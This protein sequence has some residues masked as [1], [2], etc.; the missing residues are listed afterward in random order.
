MLIGVT[1]NGVP[2]FVSDVYRGRISD[3]ELVERSSLCQLL[4]PG[5]SVMADRGF[6]VKDL[7]PDGVSLNIPPFLDRREQF[8]HHELAKMRRITSG[9]IQVERAIERIKNFRILSF[10]PAS[11][12]PIADQ[13]ILVCCVL[14]LLMDPLLPPNRCV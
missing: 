1:P 11:L 3:K 6:L 10:L 13:I 8:E 5:D 2:F 4:E 7:L 9:R 12:C 14:T